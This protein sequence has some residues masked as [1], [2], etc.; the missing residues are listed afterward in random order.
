MATINGIIRSYQA[1]ARR[2]QREQQRKARE[3]TRL[4][5]EQQKQQDFEEASQAVHNWTTYTEMLKSL[6]KETNEPIDWEEI[7]NTA[8]PV[9]P[10]YSD[11]EEAT[12]QQL[13]DNFRPSIVDKVLGKVAG[14]IKILEGLVLES[15]AKD[16]KQH[17][18]A[19]NEYN[20]ELSNWE[21]LQA[22]AQGILH[23]KKKAYVEAFNYFAPFAEL[24]E[25][26]CRAE[27]KFEENDVEVDVV[28]NDIDIV[29]DYELKQTATGKLSKK[30][31]SKS[32]YYELYQDHVCSVTLRVAREIFGLLPVEYTTVNT[33]CDLLNP[34]TGHLEKQVILSVKIPRQTL[35]TLN[36]DRIDPSDSMRNFLHNMKFRKTSGFEVVER[37]VFGNN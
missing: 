14:K 23:S 20:Q 37:V 16:K 3:M 2:T 36:L 5:K 34:Q 18:I 31:M 12:A 22:I 8:K 17:Q 7:S 35:D 24:T 30:Q 26:G 4:F 9:E 32:N 15:R 6:H 1:S 27:I 25:M 28:I 13:L 21:E 29:P 33:F 10:E 11:F 19:M